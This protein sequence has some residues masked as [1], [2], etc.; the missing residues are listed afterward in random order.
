MYYKFCPYCGNANG[1]WQENKFSCSNCK[2][3][4]YTDSK[5]TASVLIINDNKV[6]LGKRGVEPGKGMWDV[7]GGFTK[8]GEHPE[9]AAIREAKEETGLDL[10]IKEQL[11]I[12]MDEY[13]SD[14]HSTLNICYLASVTGGEAKA[15]DDII[16]LKW[17]EPNKLPANI[18]F[19]NG[20]D[21]LETWIKIKN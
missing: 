5:P 7:I 1:S 18:A 2:K 13:G 12:F 14:K 15:G 16:E 10:K 21:M 17:F 11:G 4:T 20:K 19:Q 6:L 9:T 8:Y 3:Y